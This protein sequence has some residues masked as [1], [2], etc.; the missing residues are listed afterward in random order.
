MKSKIEKV[1]VVIV[2][3]IIVTS[4]IIS[5]PLDDLDEI[6]NY[7]FARNIAI[8]NMPYKDFNMITMPLF[9]NICAIFLIIFG[10]EL[11][12]MRILAIILC[13]GILLLTNKI[14]RTLKVNKQLSYLFL[15]FIIYLFK[16]YFRIDYNFFVLFNLLAIIYIEIKNKKEISKIDILTGVLAGICICTKQTTGILI[17]LAL[18]GYPI[19]KVSSKEEFKTYL[20][21]AAYR[22]IGIAI[23][24]GITA[25]YFCIN[26]LWT[27]FID[28]CILG[29]KTFSNSVP[30]I[31][32]T[33]GK[34]IITKTLSILVPIFL[35]TVLI[36]SIIKRKERKTEY[37]NLTIITCL[38]IAEMVVAFP[39]SDEIH[40]LLGALPSLIGMMYVVSIIIKN[41]KCE[42]AKIFINEFLKI[43]ILLAS[44]IVIIKPAK[45]IY[46]YISTMNEYKELKHF[47]YIPSEQE[48]TEEIKQMGEYIKG[49]EKKTYILDPVSALYTIP[50]DV[51]NKNYDMFLK[52]NIGKDGEAGIIEDLKNEEN[53]IYLI[54][55]EEYGRNWQ[56][57][58]E[59]RKYIIENMN[60]VG[61]ILYFDIYQK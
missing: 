53:S 42:K 60:K 43:A 27:Y 59:V 18:V 28:Y 23:P 57:P 4:I 36:I 25:I 16:D 38:G 19:L 30:Y 51:Y 15:A 1:Y 37:K 48:Q 32:L 2:I 55:K 52:G 45:T 5:K 31:Y 12:I 10:N 40:F 7:N 44:L 50:I 46:E 6:W 8:G 61:E 56:N 24:I 21:K 11:I 35:L 20:K 13:T 14:L 58:E 34:N 3:L 39:I 41:I 29:I 33:K 54:K 9:P 49:Q 17:S 47:L 26:G 22:I